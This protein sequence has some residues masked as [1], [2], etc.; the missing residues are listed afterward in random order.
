MREAALWSSLPGRRRDW[1]CWRETMMLT[2][3]LRSRPWELSRASELFLAA[4][5]REPKSLACFQ[6]LR[7]EV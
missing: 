3:L 1:L 5:Q 4:S 2:C 6:A 7:R